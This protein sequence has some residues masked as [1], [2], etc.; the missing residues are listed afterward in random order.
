[1]KAKLVL[2]PG[3]RTDVL[4]K[5]QLEPGKTSRRVFLRDLKLSNTMS[6]RAAD[7]RNLRALEGVMPMAAPMATGIPIDAA[8][9]PE[10]VLAVV[11]IE[12]EPV[13]MDL[14]APAALAIIT[15]VELPPITKEI[16]Q[17]KEAQSVRLKLAKPAEVPAGRLMPTM[18]GHRHG[19][20]MQKAALPD[21]RKAILGY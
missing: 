16:L 14:P 12:G 11:V 9:K 18:R 7:A 15:P 4:V 21:Q 8:D 1:M 2:S 17:E 19:S 10:Q 20:R 3:Y 6:L 5:A 13:A